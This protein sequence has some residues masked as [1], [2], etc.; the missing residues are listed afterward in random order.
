MTVAS[1]DR[2][3][4]LIEALAG[5][6]AGLDLGLIA[7]RID[8]PKSATH[9]MLATLVQRGYVVQNPDP[10]YALSLR[11]AVLGFR[12]LDARGL[13]DMAQTA[14]DRLARSTGE[15]CR[16]AVIEG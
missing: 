10:S 3:V 11:L 6:P 4:S 14:L 16:L 13:P 8:M 9:R 12:N 15:Y 7:E 2:C 5:E 1:V